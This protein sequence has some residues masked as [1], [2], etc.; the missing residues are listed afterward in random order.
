MLISP[1]YNN[2][3]FKNLAKTKIKRLYSSTRPKDFKMA[4]KPIND[5]PDIFPISPNNILINKI[6]YKK[7]MNK[8][9]KSFSRTIFNFKKDKKIMNR[10]L[11]NQMKIIN[12][13]TEKLQAET[14]IIHKKIE[15]NTASENQKSFYSIKEDYNNSTNIFSNKLIDIDKFIKEV[16]SFLLPNDKT[17]ENIKNLI[18]DKIKKNK[19]TQKL[20][21][22]N[23]LLM[24]KKI[25]IN[26][27]NY[28]LIYRYVF[29]NTFKEAFKKAL[30]NK[31]L[32]NKDDIK[33][34]YQKQIL[35]IRLNLI[36]HNKEIKD[37]T[38]N[39]K[40]ESQNIKHNSSDL[41]VYINKNNLDTTKN[42]KIL[43]F[44]NYTRNR[45]IIQTNSSNSIF[46]NQEKS[47]KLFDIKTIYN[48]YKRKELIKKNSNSL[49]SKP[50]NN[51]L[52][53]NYFQRVIL[54]TK[55]DNVKESK[56][57]NIIRKQKIII[58]N[59]IR[60]KKI[61]NC[62]DNLINTEN[63]VQ[64]NIKVF[65]FLSNKKYKNKY[66]NEDII[67]FIN[68]KGSIKYEN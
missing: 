36:L 49:D 67:N 48:N 40:S 57:K 31:T 6:Q 63:T 24:S 3:K 8:Q 56:L 54:K 32:I 27:S 14:K 62:Q 46:F 47:K 60:L 20:N 11:K 68:N 34:E 12:Y 9:N 43:K 25:P 58:N 33:E 66:K 39:Q 59:N 45:K 5:L 17:Y 65:D 1:G 30:L 64:K 15:F 7:D 4:L 2:L 23:Q 50:Y 53:E 10:N 16:N 51:S 55:T 35:S 42:N 37:L 18:N 13:L 26:T 21:C 41:E 29:N 19:E 44:E 22:F 28:E 38:N 52:Y 61:K